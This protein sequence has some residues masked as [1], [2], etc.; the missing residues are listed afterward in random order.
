MF[1]RI[2]IP[3]DGSET[4]E[5]VVAQVQTLLL[6][7][8][9]EAVLV[10]ADPP[11]GS[12]GHVERVRRRLEGEGVRV[13]VFFVSPG[14]PASGIPDVAREE[15]VS[16]IAMSAQGRGGLF[17]SV[18]GG[19]VEQVLRASPAPVLL[20]RP[21]PRS[22]DRPVGPAPDSQRPFQNIL[23]PIGG[24]EAS[25]RAVPVAVDLAKASGGSVTVLHVTQP[26]REFETDMI[27][28]HILYDAERVLLASGIR[29]VTKVVEGDPAN[30]ILDIAQRLHADIIVMAAQGGPDPSRPVL[31]SVAEDVF[32]ASSLPML[33]V[34]ANGRARTPVQKGA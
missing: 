18:P 13:R 34:G 6:H 29:L 11:I 33:L 20:V 23:L 1:R 14:A 17:P 8:A 7:E 25:R 3:V 30:R 22:G 28:R 10:C 9:A 12:M 26:S 32:R 21:S 19:V 2:L 16:L 15:N 5:A 4:A 24:I 31:G 27:A